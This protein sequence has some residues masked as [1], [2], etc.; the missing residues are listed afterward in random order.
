M[1][2]GQNLQTLTVKEKVL[3]RLYSDVYGSPEPCCAVIDQASNRISTTGTLTSTLQASSVTGCLYQNDL[4]VIHKQKMLREHCVDDQGKS[5]DHQAVSGHRPGSLRAAWRSATSV[6]TQSCAVSP[7]ARQDHRSA[8]CSGHR[9]EQEQWRQA[10]IV[11]PFQKTIFREIPL[12][13]L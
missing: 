6:P 9:R 7:V 3:L 4:R 5:R 2:P 10:H 11:K 8:P 12:E 1:S 13:G